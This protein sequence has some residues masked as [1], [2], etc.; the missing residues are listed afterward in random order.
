MLVSRGRMHE[1]HLHTNGFEPRTFSKAL[2][3]LYSSFFKHNGRPN[4]LSVQTRP[5]SMAFSQANVTKTNSYLVVI[6]STHG[7]KPYFIFYLKA[8]IGNKQPTPTCVQTRQTMKSL[9]EQWVLIANMQKYFLLYFF[10]CLF[11]P[12]SFFPLNKWM[13][14]RH[15]CWFMLCTFC[16][17]NGHQPLQVQSMHNMDT[18]GV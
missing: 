3:Y 1:F 15:H 13:M 7:K 6:T 8:H 10:H 4:N 14:S 11:L 17:Y 5:L 16:V 2:Y 9:N 18:K 12:K